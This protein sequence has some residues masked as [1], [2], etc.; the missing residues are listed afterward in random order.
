MVII[1]IALNK[2]FDQ[3]NWADNILLFTVSGFSLKIELFD[4]SGL[5]SLILI[6]VI[7]FVDQKK[8]EQTRGIKTIF[9]PLCF[10]D[11]EP[12]MTLDSFH[13]KTFK[14]S[15]DWHNGVLKKVSEILKVILIFCFLFYSYLVTK[16]N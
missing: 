15:D 7:T 1:S 14:T 4:C 5:Q 3:L 8:R 6:C 11:K 12:Q 13:S 9:Q 16:E 2:I 10:R